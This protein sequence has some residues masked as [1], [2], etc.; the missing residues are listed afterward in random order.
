MLTSFV[1]SATWKL[2]DSAIC[3]VCEEEPVR[4]FTAE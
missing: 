4:S 3:A 1:L 2:L